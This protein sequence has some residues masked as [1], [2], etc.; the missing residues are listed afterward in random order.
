[1]KLLQYGLMIIALVLISCRGQGRWEESEYIHGF[2]GKARVNPYLAAERFLNESGI[3]AESGRFWGA[4]MERYQTVVVPASFL[5][6]NGLVN[7]ILDWVSEGRNLI[8]LLN[9]GESWVDDFNEHDFT[10]FSDAGFPSLSYLLEECA[11][12]RR[13]EDFE[14]KVIDEEAEGHLASEWHEA[15]ISWELDDE[16]YHYRV[17]FEGDEGL[18]SSWG[19]S[20]EH[21]KE[22]SRM[23]TVGYGAGS[24]MVLAHARPFRNAYIDRADHAAFLESVVQWNGTGEVMFLYGT[25]SSFF[26]MLWNHGRLAVIAFL[27]LLLVW[28]WMKI[29]RFGPV[30]N[31]SVTLKREYGEHLTSAARFLWRQKKLGHYIQPLRDEILEKKPE[32]QNQEVDFYEYLSQEHN[33]K[34]EDVQEAMSAA[35]IKDASHLLRVTKTLQILTQKLS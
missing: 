29:P 8:I 12:E 17:E 9:G 27:V 26:T 4:D 33:L 14:E 20:W 6:T 18:V 25:G 3:P 31:D 30:L 11:I 24:V 23:V 21:E 2:K 32:N 13:D 19:E 15:Q 22:G 35:N 34:L 1:M 5:S 10:A 16:S 7:Q 28:L